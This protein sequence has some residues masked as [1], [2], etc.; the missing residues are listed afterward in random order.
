MRTGTV[1]V[2]LLV[3]GW[4]AGGL[5]RG[6]DWR[7]F[8]RSASRNAVSP[9][10][11]AP[12]RWQTE[13]REH[14]FLRRPAWNVHWQARLGSS[15]VA[16]PVVAGGLVWIGTN[17]ARPRNPE[18]RKDASVLMCFREAD[19]QFLWQYLSPRLDNETQDASFAGLNCSPLVEDDRLFFTTNR[20]EVIA[21]DIAPLR[22]RKGEPRLLWKLD[23]R[24]QLGV[25]PV[26]PPMAIGFTCSLGASYRGRL[27]VTTGNGVGEDE[28]TVAAPEAPSLVCLERETGKVLWSDRSPGKNILYAQWSSPLVIEVQER[29]QVVAAQGD[30]W[31]RAFDPLTG[32][33]LWKFDTNPKAAVWK[34]VGPSTRNFLVATPVFYEGRI[35]IANG[36]SLDDGSGVGHLWCI[37]PTRRPTNEE[38]DLTPADQS[39]DPKARG[40]QDSGLVWHFGGLITPPPKKGQ[41]SW[42]FGRTMSTVA[43]HDGL[44]IAPE[45]EGYVH[46]LDAR[47]GRRYWTHDVQESLA[48]SPLIVDGKVYVPILS[49]EVCVLALEREKRVL[50]VN[51]VDEA[52]YSSPVFANG[53][54]YIAT[55]SRL[56]ALQSGGEVRPPAH[57]PQWRG[58]DRSNV[59]EETGLLR[60]WPDGGPP[61]AWKVSGLGEGV[62]SVAIAGGRVFTLGYQGESEFLTALDA[63]SGKK[64]WQARLGPALKENPVMRWLCQRTPT[65][66][67]DRLYAF[68]AQG[69]L[70]CL[71]TADGGLLWRKHYRQDFAGRTGPWGYCDRPL[72]DGDRLICVPGGEQATL[73]ALN[74]KTGAVLWKCAIPN[75]D[76]AGYA[77]TVVAEAAGV[78]QYIAFLHGSVVAV[79][80]DGRFLWRYTG[81]A[82]RTGN[83]YT[84]LVSGSA[85]FC[86][87]GY[88]SGVALLNLLP[89]KEKGAVVVEEVYTRKQ[90]LS[91]WHDGTV[92]V[93]GHVYC[94]AESKVAC[95]E[96]GTG[97]VL[98]QERGTVS[99]RVSVTCAEG[100]LYLRAQDGKV[101]LVEATPKAFTAKGLLQIPGAVAKPGSTAPVVAGGRLYLR[102]DDVLFCYDVLAGANPAAAP[103]EGAQP[104]S[105]RPQPEVR[106][107]GTRV[108]HDVFVP[109][110]QDVVERMLALAR[111][112]RGDVVHDLGCGD[113]RVVV[114]AA[115]QYGC[116]AHGCDLDP[117]CVK[118]S[119]AAVEQH[120]VGDRVT[121]ER[122]DLFTVDLS[123]AS[124]V[125]LYLLPRTSE[126]LL[127]QLGKL[128]P[129][130]RI[131]SHAFAI[132]GL[133]PERV[134]TIRSQEDDL[135]HKLYLYTVPLQRTNEA[136]QK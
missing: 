92:L 123:G 32:E 14:G 23:L 127:P 51:D 53:V 66:D 126:R 13:V 33:L 98:W 114:T 7:M 73:V 102:D 62:A 1:A 8:G 117:E 119:R 131:V 19:G 76:P 109:T 44:V 48:A 29:A 46:C 78:R 121:I 112:R 113:G 120:G 72:V 85:V 124:V 22:E 5:A 96:F 34:P 58:P 79:S 61:L 100:H 3:G 47:T 87:S 42:A 41:R 36:R 10:K 90:T 86:A 128:K 93:G 39:F 59:S 15:T 57:W 30:G 122:K 63:N 70:L 49:G 6:E 111:V 64:L 118:M 18:Y 136:A 95:L 84:P 25:S 110:P 17:N 31:V 105:S 88:G 69:E 94:G 91:A 4:L 11:N 107:P 101:A 134:E 65:I 55:G 80:A 16:S 125:T 27:Y 24:K 54:L 103:K 52:G 89:G 116:R 130:A 60:E 45:V 71:R 68:T 2:A 115:R 26:G 38:K 12:T 56:L 104:G 133:R 50:A 108:A 20:G 106:A 97:K 135:G 40:N 67:D 9:E 21:L 82:N 74:K 43:I 83:N 77:A 28:K 129:G 132:P 75:G 35:Y 81:I 99:G 37:D